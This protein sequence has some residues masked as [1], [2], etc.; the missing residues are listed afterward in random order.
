MCSTADGFQYGQVAVRLAH[1]IIEQE[2]WLSQEHA[3]GMQDDLADV[4]DQVQVGSNQLR[5]AGMPP[6]MA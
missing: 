2:S 1:F 4:A 5:Y 6:R 3:A